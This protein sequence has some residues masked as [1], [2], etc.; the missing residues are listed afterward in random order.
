MSVL[1]NLLHANR[2]AI[3]RVFVKQGQG[4][5]AL[6]ASA[7]GGERL[8]ELIASHRA[9]GDPSAAAWAEAFWREA[10]PDA[11][12]DADMLSGLANLERII[13][14]H[15]VRQ[16]ADKKDLLAA[17]GE[18]GE[19][20]D[21]L[22]RRSAK[23]RSARDA[24][25]AGAPDDHHQAFVALAEHSRDVICLATLQGKPFYLNKAGR[26][27]VGIKDGEEIPLASLHGYHDDESW[28]ELR[29]VGVP[30]VKRTGRWKTRARLHGRALREGVEVETTMFL[31]NGDEGERPTCLGLVHR[32]LD[33]ERKLERALEESDSRK[34][35]ILESSLDPI[36]TIDHRGVISE[37]N[38]AAEQVF[39]RV[40][41]EVL[42]TKPS[43]I[44]FPPTKIARHQNRIDRYLDAGEGSLLS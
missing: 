18:L 6:A 29:D 10:D 36:I 1:A 8:L 35:A 40:R 21:L 43:E 13:R 20:I 30:S 2:E 32:L 23:A 44:L 41:S 9:E 28:I 25:A 16:V 14:F 7:G 38:R 37:F 12:S 42:G 15:V 24:S 33:R 19:A 34:R 22:R 27:L 39:G 5:A 31:V 11:V 4:A 3:L 26:R 17:L